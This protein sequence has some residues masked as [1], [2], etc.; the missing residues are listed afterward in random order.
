[1][2]QPSTHNE[3][4]P[5]T[6]GRGTVCNSAQH[7]QPGRQTQP[8]LWLSE[9]LRNEAPR[10]WRTQLLQPASNNAPA[11][12]RRTGTGTGG[13]SVPAVAATLLRRQPRRQPRGRREKSQAGISLPQRHGSRPPPR[14]LAE[15]VSR[16]T[17]SGPSRGTALTFGVCRGDKGEVPVARRVE[18][19][20]LR[21]RGLHLPALR[22]DRG[23]GGGSDR[24][25][26]T[27]ALSRA[28]SFLHQQAAPRAQPPDGATTTDSAAPIGCLQGCR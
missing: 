10:R 21:A 20:L 23:A 16:H 8:A 25:A 11:A 12:P 14:S 4:L 17:A 24:R 9:S 3:L 18:R 6:R 22:G 27:R 7:S 2:V 5:A 13:P 1:M 19:R 15:P 28:S 26:G